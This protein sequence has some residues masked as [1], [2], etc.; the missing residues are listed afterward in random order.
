MECVNLPVY[1]QTIPPSSYLFEHVLEVI[2]LTAG[3]GCVFNEDVGEKGREIS[4]STQGL[5]NG[6]PKVSSERSLEGSELF[7]DHFHGFQKVSLGDCPL[8]FPFGVPKGLWEV[9]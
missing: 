2:N 6:F 5:L 3:L 7:S 4:C 8:G 1:F 9:S